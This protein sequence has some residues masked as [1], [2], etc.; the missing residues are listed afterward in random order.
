MIAFGSALCFVG[1]TALIWVWIEA[2]TGMC[3]WRCDRCGQLRI[4]H[5]RRVK[6]ERVRL[7]SKCDAD[8]RRKR[9]K[10]Q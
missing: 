8:V 6:G 5:A 4:T 1:A 3:V 2:E 9:S 10:C 7:C